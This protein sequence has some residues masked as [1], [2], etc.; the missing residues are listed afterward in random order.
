MLRRSGCREARTTGATDRIPGASVVKLG[1]SG[2][3]GWRIGEEP[4]AG[5]VEAASKKEER[6]A[7]KLGEASGEGG[8]ARAAC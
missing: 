7:V 4:G 3:G 2:S 8:G 6:L 1:L 5:G